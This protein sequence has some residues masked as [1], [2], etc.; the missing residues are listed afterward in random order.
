MLIDCDTCR[1]RGPACGDCMVTA[2]LGRTPEDVL[3]LNTTEQQ[4]LSA[5]AASGLVPPLRLVPVLAPGDR[6]STR[7]GQDGR[8]RRAAAG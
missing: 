1:A 8:N 5:L 3:E 7:T 2:M 4:A 6:R